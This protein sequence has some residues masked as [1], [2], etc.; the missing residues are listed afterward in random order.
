MIGE[1]GSIS[2][3]WTTCRAAEAS[4]MPFLRSLFLHPAIAPRF[5]W[6]GQTPS[7]EEFARRAGEGVLGQWI[8][9]LTGRP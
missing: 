2:G 4:D 9:E 3:R 7:I 1:D 5:R 6:R 8:I